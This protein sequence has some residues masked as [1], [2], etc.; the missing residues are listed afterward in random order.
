LVIDTILSLI[1][2][3]IPL[4]WGLVPQTS[5]KEATEQAKVV[6]YLQEAYG[7]AV[8]LEYLQAVGTH[9]SHTWERN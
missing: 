4:Q 6:Y 7:P 5:T 3:G 9:A 1:R 8:M 2:R